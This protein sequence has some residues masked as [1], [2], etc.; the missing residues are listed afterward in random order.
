MA[1][2]PEQILANYRQ[3]AERSKSGFYTA[4]TTSNPALGAS[5]LGQALKA[6][7][8]QGLISWRCGITSPVNPFRE[9]M[10]F[11]RQG[12]CTW[13]RMTG[14][15]TAGTLHL[16]L[17]KTLLVAFL[18]NQSLIAFD[19]RD[20]VADRLLDALLGHG[21]W[22]EWHEDAWTLGLDQ[23]RQIKGSTLAVE[24]Y[25]AYYRLLRS[26]EDGDVKAAVE[27]P[28]SFSKSGITTASIARAS[29]Q[30]AEATITPSRSI[31]A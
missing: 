8:M 19:L 15:I 24:S 22:G 29:R 27:S 3:H 28:F 2:S 31:T 12:Y 14:S 20:L 9:G 13:Q 6:Y 26:S 18:L 17:E 4:T 5:N 11:V 10:A 23:L 16:P 7:L 1:K 30:M 21:L 25:T